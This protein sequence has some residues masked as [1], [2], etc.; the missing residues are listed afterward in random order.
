MFVTQLQ[1]KPDSEPWSGIP[2]LL[3]IDSSPEGR[4]TFSAAGI[5]PSEHQEGVFTSVSQPITAV[6]FVRQDSIADPS[7]RV[8]AV[9]SY[10]P[11][12]SGELVISNTAILRSHTRA[13]MVE[14]VYS[15]TL[16]VEWRND[17]SL[18][19]GLRIAFVNE[20]EF[21]ASV[22]GFTMVLYS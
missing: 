4:Y 13:C 12:V 22:D 14:E 20:G 16:P 7:S 3:P 5:A 2:I 1:P 6:S 19:W 15:Q 10:G 18:S 8:V 11:I 17:N 21:P 9:V